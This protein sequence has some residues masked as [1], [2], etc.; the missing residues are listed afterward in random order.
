MTDD[1]GKTVAR[2]RLGCAYRLV[3]LGAGNLHV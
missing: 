3:R 2:T 1:E